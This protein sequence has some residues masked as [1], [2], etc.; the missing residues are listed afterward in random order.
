MQKPVFHHSTQPLGGLLVLTFTP[1][2]RRWLLQQG[3][4]ALRPLSVG[5]LL[6]SFP[7]STS[8]SEEPPLILKR[9]LHSCLGILTPSPD[10]PPGGPWPA[11]PP[12]W[13]LRSSPSS[14]F[15]NLNSG[16]YAAV[17]VETGHSSSYDLPQLLAATQV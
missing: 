4:V 15:L 11:R 1:H 8:S 13:A 5:C 17:R 12:F 9:P 14:P 16:R 2:G 7:I 10:P 3:G 6:K